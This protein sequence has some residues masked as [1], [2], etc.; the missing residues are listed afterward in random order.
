MRTLILVTCLWLATSPLYGKIVFYSNRD[1]NY[2]IYTMRSDGFIQIRLTFNGAND[3]YPVWSPDGDQILF[4]SDFDLNPEVYLMNADGTNRRN[5]SN[6]PAVDSYAD[7]SPDG[8]RIIFI[9]ERNPDGFPALFMMDADGGNVKGVKGW[10]LVTKP[11]W[12]P[13]GKQIAL[14]DSPIYVVNA[15]GRAPWRVSKRPNVERRQMF[16]EGWS[17][18]GTQLLFS[19]ADFASDK[20]TLVIATLEPIRRRMIIQWRRVSVPNRLQM[21]F[22]SAAFAPDA[23]SILFSGKPNDADS[24][25]IY[26]FRLADRK[27]TQLT[28]GAGDDLAPHEWLSPLSVSPQELI[29][30]RW[31]EIKTTR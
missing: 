11:K 5:L 4:M 10:R 12:S 17:P 1:G 29:P 26:R 23:K 28:D 13:T 3:S 14:G 9:S 18:D 31:G 24:W 19:E 27:L 7:W 2:E 6:H 16:L 20:D 30:T 8:S 15:Q 25:D 21:V 22:H